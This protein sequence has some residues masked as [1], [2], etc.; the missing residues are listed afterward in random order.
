MYIN[1]ARSIEAEQRY[2]PIDALT[3]EVAHLQNFRAY[4]KWVPLSSNFE[5]LIHVYS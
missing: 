3:S 1:T 5:R 4:K 2:A